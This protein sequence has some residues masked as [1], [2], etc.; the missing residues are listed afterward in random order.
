MIIAGKDFWGR[1]RQLVKQNKTTHKEFAKAC[2][3]HYNTFRSWAMKEMFP[4]VIDVYIIAKKLGV[5]VEY[6]LTGK[7]SIERKI[8]EAKID[9]VK[10]LL[11]KS[12]EKLE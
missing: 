11:Q 1:I 7:V 9:S 2:G 10:T 4:N 3:I 8:L 5:T 12:L 6:L